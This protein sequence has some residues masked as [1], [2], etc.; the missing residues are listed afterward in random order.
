[1]G[2][3]NIQK[4]IVEAMNRYEKQEKVRKSRVF[5]RKWFGKNTRDKIDL[6][7]SRI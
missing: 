6:T 1:M 7:L 4:S 3:D 5:L 2:E